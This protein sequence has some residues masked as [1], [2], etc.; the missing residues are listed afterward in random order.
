MV[1]TV[2]KVTLESFFY[3]IKASLEMTGGHLLHL[4]RRSSPPVDGGIWGGKQELE[5]GLCAGITPAA[6]GRVG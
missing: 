3:N 2:T 1:A 5:Q 6:A 4:Q